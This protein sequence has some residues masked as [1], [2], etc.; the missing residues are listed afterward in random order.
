[1]CVIVCV[2]VSFLPVERRKQ[3]VGHSCWSSGMKDVYG[4]KLFRNQLEVYVQ[5]P[6]TPC[7]PYICL[8]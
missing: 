2:Y 8:H 7:M 1:M 5:Y 6:D 3:T 4:V